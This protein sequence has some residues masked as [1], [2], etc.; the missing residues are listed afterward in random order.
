[1]RRTD[2][3][4]QP[5]SARATVVTCMLLV[6]LTTLNPYHL[7]P[8]FDLF[9]N[10]VVAMILLFGLSLVFLTA[11]QPLGLNKS[12]L[13]WLFLLPIVL[14]QPVINTIDYLDSLVNPLASLVCVVLLSIAVSSMKH[15]HNLLQWV[16][17]A[18][19]VC[20]VLSFGIQLLQLYGHHLSI[21]SILITLLGS[22]RLDANIAQP[23]QLAFMFSLA[24]IGCLYWYTLNKRR[25]WLFI[26]GVFSTGI[27]LTLSRAGIILSLATIILFY[28]FYK[29]DLKQRWLSIF[30]MSTLSALFYAVGVWL[31]RAVYHSSTVTAKM[32]NALSQDNAIARFSEGSLYMRTSLQEQ[33]YLIFT[34]QPLT[35]IGW[36]NFVKGAMSH[37]EELS[38]FA[39]SEHSHFF[40]TQIAS[41]LGVLG[42]LA[43][44]PL[45]YFILRKI[46]FSMDSFQATCYTSISIFIL[47]SCSEF[48]LWYVKYLLVF[49]F[50]IALLD[51]QYWSIS[52]SVKK[53]LTFFSCIMLL[54]SIVYLKDF[55]KVHQTFSE[56]K[57]IKLS[58][59]ILQQRYL[60]M[61]KTFGLL[62]FNEQFLFYY[63]PVNTQNLN[64]KIELAERVVP[65][66]LNRSG[67]FKYGQLLA[68][69]N[70]RSQ[71]NRMFTSAC[72][73]E[74]QNNCDDIMEQLRKL[75]VQE[76]QTYHQ[77]FVALEKW[78]SIYKKSLK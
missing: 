23:N 51:E 49:A 18:L 74:I 64:Y 69:N 52:N 36:G 56:V 34:E 53:L 5:I 68:L 48:P 30:M 11:Q 24:Q 54:G 25:Y 72:A 2:I 22:G 62:K 8:G 61:P 3:T 43:L 60:D 37:Y 40:V 16:E 7:L 26:F 15:K 4:A 70:Q 44:L 20:L 12:S 33:A 47:Y 9:P 77:H 65:S 17:L 29:Q 66:D 55:I 35:G 32:S 10:L 13:T 73:L 27:A 71:A 58:E 6:I 14:L 41:E 46:S 67:L 57:S 1:M 78:V 28:A 31:Y 39:Y 50:F 19:I 38:W 63:L 75:S 42:L 21:N 45:G 76:P 59:P